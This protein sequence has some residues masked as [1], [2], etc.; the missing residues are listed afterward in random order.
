MGYKALAIVDGDDG[1]TY[2]VSKW[3]DRHAT[4]PGEIGRPGKIEVR[5]PD[6]GGWDGLSR[7][8]A[9]ATN[10]NQSDGKVMREALNR[11]EVAF[12]VEPDRIVYD[13]CTNH[14]RVKPDGVPIEEL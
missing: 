6:G 12:G 3:N 7:W 4:V 5:D 8:S 11:L 2:R 13:Q 9:A 14:G 1:Q 10:G